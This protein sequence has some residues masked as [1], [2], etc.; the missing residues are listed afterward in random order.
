LERVATPSQRAA[1]A[2]TTGITPERILALSDKVDLLQIRGV[3]P[4][5][6]RLLQAAGV[7]HAKALSKQVPAALHSAVLEAN[8]REAIASKTPA[9][10]MLADWI[11]QAARVPVR[12]RR[13]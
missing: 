4:S 8:G 11:R 9:V 3:G 7:Q 6:V 2:K 13:R 12:I 5:M 10:E 1:L